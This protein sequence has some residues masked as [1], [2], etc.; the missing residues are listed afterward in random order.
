MS[1]S[2][3]ESS[4]TIGLDYA[5]KADS[6]NPLRNEVVARRVFWI[7]FGW[8]MFVALMIAW[9]VWAAWFGRSTTWTPLGSLFRVINRSYILQQFEGIV[10]FVLYVL[11][12]ASAVLT[13][14]S[15]TAIGIKQRYSSYWIAM[16]IV[17]GAAILLVLL[18]F[19]II[20]LVVLSAL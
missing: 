13:A 4:D 17:T 8:T 20:F 16:L 1:E 15:A 2:Q 19:G 10:L 5:R 9:H 3:D 11:C 18:L 6:S 14:I 7:E 12:P